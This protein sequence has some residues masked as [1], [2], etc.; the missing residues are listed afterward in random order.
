MEFIEISSK[1]VR[2]KSFEEIKQEIVDKLKRTKEVRTWELLKRERC[3][4]VLN[5]KSFQIGS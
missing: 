2:E 5:A 1:D 3:G 4:G